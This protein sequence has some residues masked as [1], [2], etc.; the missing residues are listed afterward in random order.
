[1]CIHRDFKTDVADDDETM[2]TMMMCVSLSV[3]IRYDVPLIILM[4]QHW[5]CSICL[6]LPNGEGNAPMLLIDVIKQGLNMDL[7]GDHLC[8]VYI[9]A[10]KIW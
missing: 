2:T 5:Q 1:M 8:I 7:L 9:S 3:Y 4:S 10:P 6:L